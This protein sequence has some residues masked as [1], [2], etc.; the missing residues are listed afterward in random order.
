MSVDLAAQATDVCLYSL[1]Y[2][3]S[4]MHV[5][6]FAA[7]KVLN[8][9]VA[10]ALAQGGPHMETTAKFVKLIFDCLNVGNCTDGK[11]S[12]NP[13]KMPYCGA[14]GFHLKVCS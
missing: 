2:Y 6:V 3:K 12:C 9:T 4:C 14:N 13:F 5:L 8:N 10:I 11:C 1:P 7:I